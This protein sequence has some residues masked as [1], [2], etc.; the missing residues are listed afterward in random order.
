MMD[1][2]ECLLLWFTSFFDKK[3]SS[4]PDKSVSGSGAAKYEIKQNL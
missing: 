4:F 1:I 2:K 3:S